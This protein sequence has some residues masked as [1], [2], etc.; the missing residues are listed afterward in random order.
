M[1]TDSPFLE[2]EDAER[3]PVTFEG[4]T[5]ELSEGTNLATAL[6]VAG[7]R[8]VRA[9][10][11]TG[12][13]RAPFCMMGACFE[14]LVEIDGVSRQACMMTVSEGMEIRHLKPAADDE[15]E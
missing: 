10:H 3:V 13:P 8:V 14:C 12:A 2:T 1:K 6:L 15:P 11:K 7:V 5:Y 4:R 9:T